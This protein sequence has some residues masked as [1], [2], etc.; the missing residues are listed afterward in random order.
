VDTQTEI[1]VILAEH[2][3]S[4]RQHTSAYVSI[5][6]HTSAYV[7]I[8]Q[9]TSAYV[10]TRQH[11]SA[12]VSIRQ[13]TEILAERQTQLVSHAKWRNLDAAKKSLNVMIMGCTSAAAYSRM[14]TYAGV[15]WRMLAY[16]DVCWRM[17]M[18]CY[19]VHCTTC[20]F[21]VSIYSNY[22]KNNLII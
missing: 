5:R 11:T 8:R 1:L 16:A 19:G 10:S 22:L 12:Y 13:Q 9:H 17:I 6:Q 7:S 3:V 2:H 15:C 14:L 21:C 4:I 18:G 20:I